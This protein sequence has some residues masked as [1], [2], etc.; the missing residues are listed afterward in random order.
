MGSL[1]S[2][3][4]K[5]TKIKSLPLK[6]EQPD[7]QGNLPGGQTKHVHQGSAKLPGTWK[8]TYGT[9]RCFSYSRNTP[10]FSLEEYNILFT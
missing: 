5:R 8:L 4:H 1:G 10:A 7:S 9:L 2:Q 6:E 3:H